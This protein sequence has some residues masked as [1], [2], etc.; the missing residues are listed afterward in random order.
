LKKLNAAKRAAKPP[1]N[2]TD[3]KST[4]Y[5]YGYFGYC[6][7]M[8]SEWVVSFYRFQVVKKTA[9][10][11]YYLATKEHIDEL[12]GE[13]DRE[14]FR[15]EGRIGF[16]DRLTLEADGVV[17]NRGRHWSASDHRLYPSL[18]A[19]RDY[20]HRNDGKEEVVDVA[21]LKQ[22]MADA[23]PD[24]GG[25]SAAFIA[26]RQKYVD[27]RRRARSSSRRAP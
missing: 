1:S 23:H 2:S 24:R 19:L 9:K 25:T 12:T 21:T 13:P 8:T 17:T 5:L 27:A 26:A 6:D 3:S 14:S 11:I 15:D 18:R 16:V 4:E 10:R 22:A 20:I 7:D